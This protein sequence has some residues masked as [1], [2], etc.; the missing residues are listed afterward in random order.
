MLDHVTTEFS[1]GI[2][3]SCWDSVCFVVAVIL[4]QMWHVVVRFALQNFTA[5]NISFVKMLNTLMI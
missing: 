2:P 4:L 1:S 3:S 5:E